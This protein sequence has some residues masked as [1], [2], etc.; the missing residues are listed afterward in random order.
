MGKKRTSKREVRKRDE[1]LATETQIAGAA[2]APPLR[3]LDQLA[4]DVLIETRLDRPLIKY[5][6][7][8]SICRIEGLRAWGTSSSRPDNPHSGKL[9]LLSKT[10]VFE[11]EIRP[12]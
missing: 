7:R 4:D 11:S 12:S 6:V 9:L 3:P 1:K 5:P 2:A 10:L 8:L